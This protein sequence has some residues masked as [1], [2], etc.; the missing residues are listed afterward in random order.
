MF[1]CLYRREKEQEHYSPFFS[2]FLRLYLWGCGWVC[3]CVFACNFLANIIACTLQ[4]SV[5]FYAVVLLTEKETKRETQFAMVRILHIKYSFVSFS[6][7]FFFLYI[8]TRVHKNLPISSEN[9]VNRFVIFYFVSSLGWNFLKNR[10]S[11]IG[12]EDWKP[13]LEAI[14]LS[15]NPKFSL[16]NCQCVKSKKK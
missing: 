4:F 5:D 13:A 15:R 8:W 14:W 9:Q 1:K 16:L 10:A 2:F 7:H 12:L 6:S 3:V 11:L